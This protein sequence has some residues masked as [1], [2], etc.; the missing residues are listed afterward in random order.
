MR[1]LHGMRRAKERSVRLAM[2]VQRLYVA[3]VCER[4]IQRRRR[5]FG[6]H[7]TLSHRPRRQSRN[8]GET[9]YDKGNDLS[10]SLFT[11]THADD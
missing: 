6:Q 7:Q 2:A 4:K 11:G 3:T 9:G 1:M 10:F 5:C 8:Y